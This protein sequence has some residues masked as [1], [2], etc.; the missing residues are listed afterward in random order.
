MKPKKIAPKTSAQSAKVVMTSAQLAAYQ[1]AI[2]KGTKLYGALKKRTSTARYYVVLYASK[3]EDGLAIHAV[4]PGLL[5]AADFWDERS[6][7]ARVPGAGFSA[8]QKIC[9]T[10]GLL[11]WGDS[12]ALRYES[13]S[14]T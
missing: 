8:I 2:P 7:S 4:S 13:L 10:L 11:L 14:L 3:E 5:K 1:R 12:R 9:E 6:E